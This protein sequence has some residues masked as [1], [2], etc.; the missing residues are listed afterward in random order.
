MREQPPRRA[1]ACAVPNGVH[2]LPRVMLRFLKIRYP[3][4]CGD[5]VGDQRPL[6]IGEIGGVTT[7]RRM[8]L[9]GHAAGFGMT[10]LVRP[11][12]LWNTLSELGKP[13]DH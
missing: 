1:R 10:R 5:Q 13:A 4:R 11:N 12:F 6:G 3:R 7:P 2:E 9:D 8:V